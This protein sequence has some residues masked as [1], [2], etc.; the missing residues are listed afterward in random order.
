[1][2]A[3]LR[4][5]LMKEGKLRASIINK[6]IGLPSTAT[7]MRHFGS[8]RNVYRLIGYTDTKHCRYLDTQRRWVDWST[9]HATLLHGQFEK[10]GCQVTL[11][12]SVKCL[13]LKGI[14]NVCFASA[15]WTRDKRK[16][17]IQRWAMWRRKNSPSGWVIAVRLN[18]GG[19]DILDY[20][21]VPSTSFNSRLLRFSDKCRSNHKIERFETF[22]E[23]ARSLIERMTEVRRRG[24]STKLRRS[25]SR[26]GRP[27][28]HRR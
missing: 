9:E 14:A 8:L 19:D 6:T 28:G 25:K 11:D 10:A 12:E 16:T 26:G 15:R 5:V 23:L 17:H 13:K 7:Y 2:L 3:R 22:D 4:R 18:Q 27:A 1:M 20:L 24:T 21:L